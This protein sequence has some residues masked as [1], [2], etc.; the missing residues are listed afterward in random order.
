MSET[1]PQLLPVSD[2]IAENI[3]SVLMALS[4]VAEGKLDAQI[5]VEYPEDHPLGALAIGIN[6]MTRDLAA[7]RYES[8]RFQEELKQKLEIIEKQRAAVRELSTPI[9]EVWKGVLCLPV[10]GVVDTVRSTEMTEALLQAVVNKSV[11]CVIVDITGI[12]VMDTRTADHFL[13][14]A[15]A[16]RL[17]GARCLLSG[18]NPM[19]AQTMVH[20]GVDL[21]G[22]ECQRTLRNALKLQLS[23]AAQ[24]GGA[25]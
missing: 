15:K 4:D 17:L 20:M 19:I 7:T 25:A 16:V 1:D 24:P 10:V 13:R 6:Q 18:V 8:L 9:I 3:V 12:E 11:D 23:R 14:M 21:H 5:P 2:E 22:L